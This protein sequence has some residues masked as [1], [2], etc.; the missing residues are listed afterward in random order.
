MLFCLAVPFYF[1]IL[2]VTLFLNPFV[3]FALCN[4]YNFPKLSMNCIKKYCLLLLNVTLFYPTTLLNYSTLCTKYLACSMSNQALAQHIMPLY[5][6]A[7]VKEVFIV[8][9]ASKQSISWIF[10]C[11]FQVSQINFYRRCLIFAQQTKQLVWNMALIKVLQHLIYV[12]AGF[13]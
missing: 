9:W 6:T 3:V 5:T 8:Y 10:S 4:G 2:K 11:S 1:C 7:G 12:H 13:S